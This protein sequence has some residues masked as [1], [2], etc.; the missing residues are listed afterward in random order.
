[1]DNIKIDLRRNRDQWRTL[2]NTVMNSRVLQNVEQFF[3]NYITGGFSRRG[4]LHRI[5]VK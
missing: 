4:Q 5:I 1:V 3:S 2:M